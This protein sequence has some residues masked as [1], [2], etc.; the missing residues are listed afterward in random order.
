MAAALAAPEGLNHLR[1]R[2]MFNA[3]EE[4]IA[5]DIVTEAERALA[6]VAEGDDDKGAEEEER[7]LAR[8]RESLAFH[9]RVLCL[10]RVRVRALVKELIL[11]GGSLD[12]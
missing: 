3:R 9:N 4:A 11:R 10:M 12:R 7:V 6:V 8:L 2:W 5:A 1:R